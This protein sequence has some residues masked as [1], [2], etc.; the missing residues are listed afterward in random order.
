MQGATKHTNG[1]FKRPPHASVTKQTVFPLTALP[2]P[3]AFFTDGVSH[4]LPCGRHLAPQFPPAHRMHAAPILP[5]P[6]SRTSL[7]T[8]VRARP[9]LHAHMPHVR[10]TS[11]FFRIGQRLTRRPHLPLA[12]PAHHPH[13]QSAQDTSSATR[14]SLRPCLHRHAR[15]SLP[16]RYILRALQRRH[17]RSAAPTIDLSQSGCSLAAHCAEASPPTYP[18][19]STA[20]LFYSSERHGP[21]P[22]SAYSAGPSK[23]KAPA[24]G[25]RQA[26]APARLSAGALRP[27]AVRR[28]R[29]GNAVAA[30]AGRACAPRSR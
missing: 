3:N 23:T 21:T 13:M 6:S 26:H 25:H 19:T 12:H 16:V 7:T 20:W 24:R 8:F 10:R 2:L 29:L 5:F 27:R 18:Y 11:T 28:V 22:G 14:G 15:Q 17:V 9:P 4:R 1:C 30:A